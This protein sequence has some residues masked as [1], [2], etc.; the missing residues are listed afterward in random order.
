M[1]V[2]IPDTGKVYE[3]I[4]WVNVFG[5]RLLV[6]GRFVGIE[7]LPYPLVSNV[8]RVVRSTFLNLPVEELLQNG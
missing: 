7:P 3:E 8:G 5:A 2:A 4:T 1:V 6:L